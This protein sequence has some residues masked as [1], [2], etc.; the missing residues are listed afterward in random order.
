M[1]TTLLLAGGLWMLETEVKGLEQPDP[2]PSV[3][4]R[5][6]QKT[7]YYNDLVPP[8]K[9]TDDCMTDSCLE[10]KDR[11]RDKEVRSC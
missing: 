9:A 11:E 6:Y 2:Q 7:K 4:E 1:L 5:V 10:H 3:V 8:V